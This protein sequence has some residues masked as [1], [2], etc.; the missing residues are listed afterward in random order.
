MFIST[1]RMIIRQVHLCSDTGVGFQ[2]QWCV[3]SL[4]RLR[5]EDCGEFETSLGNR[6][7][8]YLK[9]EKKKTQKWGKPF[10]QVHI[11]VSF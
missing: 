11:W 9:K 3:K 5:Q 1:H 6:T 4:K 10:A 2:A 8:Y 7:R